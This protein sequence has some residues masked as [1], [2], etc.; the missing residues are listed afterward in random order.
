ML[1]MSNSKYDHEI[2]FLVECM[3]SLRYIIPLA[4]RLRSTNPDVKI[5]FYSKTSQKYNCPKRNLN[6]LNEIL[7]Q[8]LGS[9]VKFFDEKNIVTKIKTRVLLVVESVPSADHDHVFVYDKKYCIQHGTD[10][11]NFAIRADNKTTYLTASGLYSEIIKKDYNES[12]KIIES[13]IPISLWTMNDYEYQRLVGILKETFLKDY[14]KSMCIFYPENGYH[15]EVIDIINEFKNEYFIFIKQ[16]AKN[17]KPHNSIN[18]SENPNVI[19]VYDT[20]WYP[21]EAVILPYICDVS[22]GFGT[23]AYVDIVEYGSNFVD[24]PLPD[25]SNRY[26]KPTKNKNF[27]IVSNHKEAVNAINELVAG[28]SYRKIVNNNYIELDLIDEITK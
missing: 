10:Y 13:K 14:K 26:A 16:R 28:K 20:Y 8:T 2:T 5:T 11:E 21:S 17:Q 15:K 24:W 9:E 18:F 23:S 27:R 19:V 6:T 4:K 25:Y 22:V 1:N 12:L 7:K 3:T